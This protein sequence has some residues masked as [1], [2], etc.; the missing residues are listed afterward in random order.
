MKKMLILSS[1]LLVL[2]GCKDN[3]TKDE[4]TDLNAA[5]NFIQSALKGDF[6]TAEK[7]MVDDSLN[8]EDLWNIARLNERLSKDEKEAYKGSTIRIHE[9]RKVNDSA[10]IITYSNSYRNKIDSLKV[11]KLNGKWLVDFKYIF[12]HKID[13][14]K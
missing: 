1:I 8:K 14:L 12:N 5:T 4:E 3:D 10:T 13:S 9:N 2:W 7:Y 11:V 6:K